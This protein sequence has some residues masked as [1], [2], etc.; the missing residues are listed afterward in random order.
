MLEGSLLPGSAGGEW[1][2]GGSPI[3]HRTGF[4]PEGDAAVDHLR[5]GDE[6]A[7]P[8]LAQVP[9]QRPQRDT[10]FQHHHAGE[11]GGGELWSGT[12]ERRDH[13]ED[14]DPVAQNR[15]AHAGGPSGR[16]HHDAQPGDPLSQGPPRT[17]ERVREKEERRAEQRGGQWVS[18]GHQH[19]RSDRDEKIDGARQRPAPEIRRWIRRALAGRINLVH[20]P[21]A[22]PGRPLAGACGGVNPAA[23]GPLRR[24]ST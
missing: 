6:I 13:A 2:G 5:A 21:P 24:R 4:Q 8:A 9:R 20:R 19:E 3:R 17:E 12:D 23:I 10:G 11:R 15:L 14:E 1:S 7:E 22:Q 16:Q 18:A